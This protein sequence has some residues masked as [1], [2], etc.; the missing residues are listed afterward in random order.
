MRLMTLCT[1]SFV[2][3][4]VAIAAV[5]TPA[6]AATKK[7]VVTRS[8]ATTV[9]VASRPRARITVQRRSFLDP[10]TQ[11]LP[12][13]DHSTDY[14]NPPGYSPMSVIENTAFYRRSLPGPWDLPSGRNPWIWNSCPGC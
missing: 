1:L 10:G 4:L 7:R 12:G 2:A 8:T 9:V 13:T 3:L 11:V 14:I 6:D 5:A